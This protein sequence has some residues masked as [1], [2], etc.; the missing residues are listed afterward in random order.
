[1]SRKAFYDKLGYEFKDEKLFETAV[2]H[3]SYVREIRNYG[4]TWDHL[5][6]K[7]IR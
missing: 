2:T 6:V 3:S 5:Y 7:D 1:M 4:G